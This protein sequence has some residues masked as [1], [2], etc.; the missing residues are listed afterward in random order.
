MKARPGRQDSSFVQCLPR[1]LEALGP[2]PSILKQDKWGTSSLRLGTVFAFLAG[3]ALVGVCRCWQHFCGFCSWLLQVEILPPGR[4]L[5]KLLKV[6]SPK[7][8]PHNH[9][10]NHSHQKRWGCLKLSHWNSGTQPWRAV[11]ASWNPARDT[12]DRDQT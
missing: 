12:C 6:V 5:R 1:I 11:K 3:C 2:S 9:L 4:R 8:P 10:S 7:A